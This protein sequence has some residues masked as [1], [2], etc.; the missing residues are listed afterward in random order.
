MLYRISANLLSDYDEQ[1]DSIAKQLGPAKLPLYCR[2]L[3]N[4]KNAAKPPLPA[5]IAAK[6]MEGGNDATFFD[7]MKAEL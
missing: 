5:P 1:V 2:P 6:P 4:G 3:L 7:N